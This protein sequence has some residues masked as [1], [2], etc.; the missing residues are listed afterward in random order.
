MRARQFNDEP[1]EEHLA[2][3]PCRSRRQFL[4]GAAAVI[5]GAV[6]A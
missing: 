6:T 5:F 1:G 4:K 3:R 2:L